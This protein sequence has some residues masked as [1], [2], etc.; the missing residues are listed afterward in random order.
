M[1]AKRAVQTCGKCGAELPRRAKSLEKKP[2]TLWGME[3]QAT[4]RI[5]ECRQCGERKACID[6][7]Y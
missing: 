5:Y 4:I 6:A 1:T 2:M 3:V 7:T